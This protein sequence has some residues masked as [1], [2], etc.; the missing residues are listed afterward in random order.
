[1][2]CTYTI[3]G[4]DNVYSFQELVNI[5][6]NSDISK[7]SDIIYSKEASAI[8][9]RVADD[10]KKAVTEAALQTKSISIIDGE[11]IINGTNTVNCQEF[12]DTPIFYEVAHI[13]TLS[14]EGYIKNRADQIMVEEGLSEDK[15]IKIAQQEVDN[16]QTIGE[17]GIT[18]H[19]VISK[20]DF[21]KKEQSDFQKALEGTKFYLTSGT[22]YNSLNSIRKSVLSKIKKQNYN[23]SSIVLNNLNVTSYIE[24]LDKTLLGHMDMVVVDHSG[25]VHLFNYK[26]TTHT[27]QDGSVKMEKYRYQLALIK[28]ILASKGISVQNA[29]LHIIPIR[30]KYTEDYKNIISAEAR[31]DRE[32]T[33]KNSNYI[34]SKYDRVAKH[35][36]PTNV[37]VRD[38]NDADIDAVNDQLTSIFPDTDIKAKG[39][40]IAAIDWIK[41]NKGAI[42][43]SIKPEYAYEVLIDNALHYIKSKETPQKNE[44]IIKLVEK[45]QN[46]LNI[47][48]PIVLERV[49]KQI[50][51]GVTGGN[52]EFLTNRQYARN[53]VFLHKVF[54]KYYATFEEQGKPPKINWEII[55][56]DTLLSAGILVFRN[57]ETGVIDVVSLSGANLNSKIKLKRGSTVL[58]SRLYDSQT[59]SLIQYKSTMGNIEAVRTIMLLNQVM[60]KIQGDFSLNQLKIVSMQETGQGLPLNFKDFIQTCLTPIIKELNKLPTINIQN[61][62]ANVSYTDLIDTLT[63]EYK[64]ALQEVTF[65]NAENMELIEDGF[66]NLENASTVEAKLNALRSIERQMQQNF[67]NII[68]NPNPDRRYKKIS[69]LYKQILNAITYYDVG[70]IST[71]QQS[72]STLDRQVFVSSKV[73]NRNYQIITELYN[74]TINRIAEEAMKR[75]IPI[76]S[77]FNN[78]YE[79]I[80]YSRLQNSTIG[81]QA[82]Q[83]DDLYKKDAQGNN[84]LR[85]LNP[86]DNTEM[87]QIQTHREEKRQFLKRILFNFAKTRYSM[88]NI[89]FNYTS[90]EDPKL[91][92][93]INQHKSTYFNI[94]LERASIS[95]R[96][97]K[98]SLKQKLNKLKEDTHDLLRDP[99]RIVE[100]FINKTDSIEE[101]DL[102]EQ[103][104]QA[105]Q[106]TNKFIL[107]EGNNRQN[108]INEHGVEF[109][110]TNL[111]IL[112]ADFIERNIET[113]EYNKAL[114]TVKGVLFQLDLLGENPN[115]QKVVGD[116]TKMIDDFIKT[117]VFH[118]SI[119]ESTSQKITGWLTPL[120][121]LVSN[122]L[123]AGNIIGMLRDTFEGVW[124]NTMRAVNK[125]QTDISLTSLNKAYGTVLKNSFTDGRSINIVNQLCQIYRLSNIDVS[126]ISEGLKSGRGIT[127]IGN[128]MYSTLRRPDFLN[129]MVL[130]VARCY[131]DGVYDAFDIKNGALVYD[132]KKDKRF[133]EFAE[134]DKSDIKKYEKAMGLYYNA[135]RT[136]NKEHPENT[137]SLKDDLPMPYSLQE[138][139]QFKNVANSI[140][141]S[142][143]RSTR[144]N[145]EHLA[146]GIFFGQFSTWMNG[147]YTNYFMKPGQYYNTES[148]LEQETD[149]QGNFKYFDMLGQVIIKKTDSSGAVHYYYEGSAKEATENIDIVEPFMKRI[150]M[151]VQGIFYTLKDSG[152]ALMNGE[153]KDMIWKDPM[154]RAN[155]RKIF[156]DLLAWLLFGT[157]YSLVANP[158]YKE[159]KKGMSDRPPVVNGAVEL[160]YKSSSRSYDGFRGVYNVFEYLGENT[161][162]PV[163]SQNIKLLTE[164]GKVAIG[165]RSLTD[166]LNGNIA[167][168]KTFQDSWR[169]T[170][171]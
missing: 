96:R 80:G 2:I 64:T 160:L 166:A 120:R 36:I 149:D 61:N 45:S 6:Q 135:I 30:L 56:N 115:L 62:F 162:P 34:F 25:T 22:L 125:Y 73:P 153:F 26:I 117:N 69:I 155:L 65:V 150:P 50:V 87:A 24:E 76:R 51:A 170:N 100:Q 148:R 105:R 19:N 142:Y 20:F 35:F 21:S 119:M 122:T 98:L 38:I 10:L 141:G 7:V 39:M 88:L 106:L 124:Q 40:R 49:I 90:A 70:N 132:W 165:K 81:N 121:R 32:F 151:V 59:G 127:N 78:F 133:K 42:S 48:N 108:Y 152:R 5:I 28:Q 1:M 128:W 13:T 3:K 55:Q 169:A 156:S 144:S 99:K 68:N 18:L 43:E 79:T 85:L 110:E 17:D 168:F 37:N 92:D 103:S 95:T 126:R 159:F 4:D 71:V 74:R 9:Q 91:L 54:S 163:Y 116:T 47:T 75:W 101:T 118:M 63:D 31:P 58:G 15:A 140:Y 66:N 46:A 130:F 112:M 136:Y 82:N 139:E 29:T 158:A 146:L 77:I 86:Y 93:F 60:P 52:S 14:T 12:I 89:P 145:Y 57:K 154:Q 107:G 147:L 171:K 41:H 167:V 129:R 114:V 113:Q 44:E 157:I 164:L 143:D 104:W 102:K 131:E 11:P 72:I 53:G 137:I 109:F 94:P 161:N 84:E 16:W 111:E 123:I 67:P 138:I 83:F 23:N 97:S 134:N 27:L 8:Q 33:I